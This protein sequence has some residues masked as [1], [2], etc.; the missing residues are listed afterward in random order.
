MKNAHGVHIQLRDGANR[1]IAGYHDA[2]DDGAHAAAQDLHITSHVQERPGDIF[3]V[4]FW[5]DEHFKL[6]DA[7]GVAIT[8][9]CGHG[10]NPPG[11]FQH[12]QCF[13]LK[14][15]DI[16]TPT[17]EDSYKLWQTGVIGEPTE[18]YFTFPVP[19]SGGT[20]SFTAG[21][22]EGN[23]E[24]PQGSVVV[25]VSRGDWPLGPHGL[26]SVRS[27]PETA[28][29][30]D[31]VRSVRPTTSLPGLTQ[32]RWDGEP[33]IAIAHHWFD[34]IEGN[35]GQSYT[36][37]FKN[38]DV[39]EIFRQE[40]R[41]QLDAGELAAEDAEQTSDLEYNPNKHRKRKRGTADK[42]STRKQHH[43]GSDDDCG[44]GSRSWR[45]RLD[46]DQDDEEI[47]PVKTKAC[48][49]DNGQRE[50]RHAAESLGRLSLQPKA[51]AVSRAVT[52]AGEPQPVAQAPPGTPEEEDLYN[53]SRHPS[54]YRE[55]NNA[56]S[57]TAVQAALQH[58][59]AQ[60]LRHSSRD[61]RGSV[62]DNLDA[63]GQASIQ[64]QGDMPGHIDLTMADAEEGVQVKQEADDTADDVVTASLARAAGNSPEDEEDLEI[65]AEEL[66]LQREDV[67]I[68]REQL[69]V[70]RR[71]H[72]IKKKKKKREGN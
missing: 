26:P 55:L 18:T 11:G 54:L 46:E 31:D 28:T 21:T 47:L 56:Q 15:E 39:S 61:R 12:R 37:E 60:S 17:W 44:V 48:D 72:A 22:R 29:E 20:E 50:D 51:E 71:Q 69:E 58:L 65:R 3:Q 66:R 10:V 1:L 59:G 24:A 19:K 8:I 36:F 30:D 52:P 14:P 35:L 13:W 45:A 34:R 25:S 62:D 57:G 38:L 43:C 33:P 67:R 9:T 32:A 7:S 27:A 68:Q 5:F 40:G 41:F 16:S 4:K 70:R 63:G 23:L 6:G 53:D 49:S 42:T 2:L 64:R